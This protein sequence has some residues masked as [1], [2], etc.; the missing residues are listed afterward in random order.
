MV[1]PGGR[2]D[3]LPAKVCRVA[4]AP[5]FRG[6]RIKPKSRFTTEDTEGTEKFFS[7]PDTP[8]HRTFNVQHPTDNDFRS[9]KVELKW[10]YESGVEPPPL[11]GFRP[12]PE[13]VKT[14]IHKI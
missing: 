3:I 8:K 10:Q 7:Q 14:N 12:Q 9:D 13:S 11:Y 2:C 5:V 6:G 1:T 4:T